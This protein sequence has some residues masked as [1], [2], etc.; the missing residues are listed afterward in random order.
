MFTRE[1]VQVETSNKIK[2]NN[3]LRD[4]RNHESESRTIRIPAL[5]V[6]RA[7]IFLELRWYRVTIRP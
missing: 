7:R 4:R 2:M 3:T 5:K 6:K 1:L